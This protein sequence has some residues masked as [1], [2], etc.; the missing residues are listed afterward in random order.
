MTYYDLLRVL[1]AGFPNLTEA[2]SR[3][4]SP[5]DEGYNC[6]AWAAEDTERW[7]WPDAKEQFYWPSSVSREETIEAF[8][9]AYGLR[10]YVQRSDATLEP[11]KQ[12]IAIY[13][14][15][16]GRPTHAARQLRDGWW[17]SKLGQ[18]IDIEHELRALDGP[19]YGAV[20]IFL[21]R[22]NS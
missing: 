12:K 7:W 16:N 19:A 4:T 8:V 5:Y 9:Q 14:D 11:G 21:A 20:T 1:H 18:Q 10:G 3:P 17:A 2:N 15:G 13:A 6:I 22:P